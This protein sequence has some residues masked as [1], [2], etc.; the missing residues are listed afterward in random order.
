MSEKHSGN[1]RAVAWAIIVFVMPVL[2]LLS[3]PPMECL[4]AHYQQGH[5]MA[6]RWVDEYVRP[7]DWAIQKNSLQPILFEYRVWWMDR[8]LPQ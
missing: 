1:P 7:Y 5:P 8:W 2:Y 6:M 4:Q 3:V